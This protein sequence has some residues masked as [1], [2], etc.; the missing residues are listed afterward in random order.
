[1]DR[2]QSKDLSRVNGHGY[3]LIHKIEGDRMEPGDHIYI[4]EYGG[5]TNKHGIFIGES[6]V[7]LYCSERKEIIEVTLDEFSG[8]K[9]IRL[10]LYGQSQ[11]HA[12]VKRL[13]TA[14]TEHSKEAD[15]VIASAKYFCDNPKKWGYEKKC[16]NKS[17]KFDN[18]CKINPTPVDKDELQ[19]GDHISIERKKGS[20]SHHGIYTGNDQVVHFTKENKMSPATAT[21]KSDSLE[22]FAGRK[23]SS[24]QFCRYSRKR[25]LVKH[26]KDKKHLF[27]V[28]RESQEQ[29]V[30]YAQHFAEH[31]TSWG[32]YN[33]LYNNCEHFCFQMTLG[34]KY[35]IS[36]FEHQA[37]KYYKIF[38][39]WRVKKFVKPLLEKAKEIR[40]HD[41]IKYLKEFLETLSLQEYIETLSHQEHIDGT[42]INHWII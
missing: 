30:E 31:P 7:I 5:F 41:S 4:H 38:G 34:A 27:E 42:P 36:L 29:I 32:E 28:E 25:L 8:D 14:F 21:I 1:M 18:H 3:G 15:D 26:P 37:L 22:D 20:Y 11:G 19:P 2:Y 33:L 39:L 40:D 23:N 17:E 24:P 35:P 13:G 9:L 12:S 10:A 16:R 6:K